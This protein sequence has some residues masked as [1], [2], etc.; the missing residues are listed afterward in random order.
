MDK[1]IVLFTSSHLC[2]KLIEHLFSKNILEGI[3]LNEK[4]QESSAL[5]INMITQM[6]IPY[7]QFD[8]VNDAK[9]IKELEKF[10]SRVGLAFGFSHKL[11]NE[12]IKHFNQ[13][14]FNI[15]PSFLPK[16]RGPQPLFWQIKNSEEKIAL[17]I[18]KVTQDMDGGDIVLQKEIEIGL[19]NTIGMIY[20][21]ISMQLA[22]LVEEFIKL[23]KDKSL[24]SNAQ[25]GKPSNAPAI[26]QKD[27]T[28]DWKD[29]SSN[30]IAALVNACNPILG[31]A[32]TVWKNIYIN[33]L[34]T[35]A[36]DMDN[37]GLE[38]GTI[39]HIGSPE[40]LIVATKDGSIRLD[41][42]SIPDGVFSGL[43]FAKHFNIYVGEKF[44]SK[45]KKG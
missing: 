37:L 7:F 4:L 30:Q 44:S 18:H 5:V 21:I 12:I 36:M 13:N 15:H 10:N 33:I 43:R 31:G 20:G 42:I 16:Y 29:M 9:N 35:T 14:I 26:R 19:D 6:N 40:G 34:Q 28:I 25:I 3:V 27:L 38:P 8:S 11:S 24:V 32:K 22:H 23:F 2:L 45:N 39:I 41:I 1:K 17:T